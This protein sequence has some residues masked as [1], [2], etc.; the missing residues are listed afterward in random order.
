[1]NRSTLK[2]IGFSLLSVLLFSAPWLLPGCGWLLLLAWV[3]ILWVEADFSSRAAKGCWKYYA[4]TFLLWNAFTTYWIYKATLLGGIAAV[5]GNA[6]QM[7][8][9]FALFRFVKRKTGAK[10]GY[11]FLATLWIAWEYFYF[12]AE[13]SWPWL[14]LGNGFADTT[15][16][17]Q[18]YE[19]TGVLGGSLWVFLSNINLL[20]WMEG[21]KRYAIPF[22]VVVLLPSAISIVRYFTYSERYNPIEVVVLQPNIDPYKEKFANGVNAISQEEQDRRLL[23]LAEQAIRPST[24][25]VFAPET[26]VSRVIEND[27]WKNASFLRIHHFLQD[28]PSTAFV[29]GAESSYIYPQSEL[30]PTETATKGIGYW[31]DNFNAAVQLSF[32]APP[33]V[34]HK[35]KLVPGVEMQPY[36]KYLKIVNKFAIDLGGA[37][38]SFA[39]QAEST[40]FQAPWNSHPSDSMPAP[41]SIGVAICYESI[42][43]EYFASYVKKG[44]G[45]M[46]VI[47]N[48]GWWGNTP[49]YN[50]HLTYSCLRAIE[51]RRSIA[52][53][54]NNGISALINQRGD[55]LQKSEWWTKTYLRGEIN[56]NHTLTFYVRYGD[57]IG[58]VSV[59]LLI[60]LIV[61]WLVLFKQKRR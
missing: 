22:M 23:E 4:L 24:R 12:D 46:S 2:F 32:E 37:V 42:Y 57:I 28:H 59:Y 48:D 18:W 21:K 20:K 51:T 30:A 31:Y 61:Y 15:L 35:S 3:P 49:G 38:G 52:R 53:S 50:Q 10:I 47:T 5:T 55:Y 11:L 44:A 1:M 56:I 43:G 40:I 14:V 29:V 60:L 27:I 25:Y 36:S 41:L 34:Y 16:L 19:Y 8:L 39:T 9:I 54:A 7:F 58:R 17:V 45:F 13:I 26:A 33:L 6:L